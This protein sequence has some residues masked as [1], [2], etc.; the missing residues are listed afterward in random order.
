MAIAVLGTIGAIGN[1]LVILSIATTPDLRTSHNAFVLNLSVADFLLS[2][3]TDPLYFVTVVL[4][5]W[6]LGPDV[7]RL[8]VKIS[9]LL[10]GVSVITLATVATNRYILIVKPHATYEKFCGRNKIIIN[11]VF[12]WFQAAIVVFVVAEYVVGVETR[13]SP[14]FASCS[15]DPSDPDTRVFVTALIIIVVFTSLVV[16]PLLYCL[17]F[18][19]IRASKRRVR[20]VAVAGVSTTQDRPDPSSAAVSQAGL[21]GKPVRNRPPEF[22]ISKEE[23][24]LVKMTL[25]VTVLFIICWLPQ[26]VIYVFG[27]MQPVLLQAGRFPF[28][29]LIL[30]PALNP[31]IYA[32]MN[33]N[34]RKACIRLIKCQRWRQGPA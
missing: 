10:M 17:M 24:S 13:Y 26:S 30:G 20:A 4:N 19:T 7:C 23:I 33:T 29:L 5:R 3:I 11:I 9:L 25:F 1:L 27:S 15:L 16:I 34:M 18:R 22:R 2:V 21:D 28:F 8:A 14:I 32:W 6:P 31:F 12:M